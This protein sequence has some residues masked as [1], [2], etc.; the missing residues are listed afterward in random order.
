M[1]YKYWN[2]FI[3]NWLALSTHPINIYTNGP[4]QIIS[5]QICGWENPN[6]VPLMNDDNK[7]QFSL[8]YLPEPWW[9]NDGNSPLNSVIINYNPGWAE[10]YKHFQYPTIKNL[11]NYPDYASFVNSEVKGITNH[12]PRT[13]NWH[14]KDRAKIVFDT[15]HRG[16]NLNINNQS[17][18]HLSI[19][20]IPWHT[21]NIRKIQ[22]YINRNL[23]QIYTNNI[24]FAADQSR[25][26]KNPKLHKKVI[27]RSS[28]TTTL[29]LLKNIQVAGIASYS[30]K[31][32]IAYTPVLQGG[33]TNGEGGYFKFILSTHPDVEFICIWGKTS[34]NKFPPAVEMDWIFTRKV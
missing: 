21:T 29:R 32:P 3:N 31:I 1:S 9:G 33:P 26:I 34:R 11:Y 8:E 20:L 25:R 14:W 15:L 28:G 7:P 10:P 16:V 24:A 23:K 19:E 13:N 27:M 22:A 12:F 30:I 18:N 2:D 5:P 4:T 6:T 17:C